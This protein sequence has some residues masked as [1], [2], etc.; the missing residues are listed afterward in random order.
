MKLGLQTGPDFA[1]L[2]KGSSPAF[3]LHVPDKSSAFHG[4]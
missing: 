1:V 3:G 2:S 4:R